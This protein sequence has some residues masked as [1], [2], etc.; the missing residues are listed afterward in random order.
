MKYNV[1][2]LGFTVPSSWGREL[3]HLDDQ[4][5]VQTFKFGWS[6]ARAINSGVGEVFLASSVPIQNYPRGRKI[7]FK[8]GRFA[9]GGIEGLMLGFV[10]VLLLKHVTRLF[11]CLVRLPLEIRRR[12]IGWIVLHGV[13]TPFL[14]FGLLARLFGIRLL[15]TLTDPAGVV[16]PTDSALTRMLKRCDASFIRWMVK[17]A[18][19]Y[20][21]LSPAMVDS[22]RLSKPSICFPGILNAGFQQA[23]AAIAR[24]PRDGAAERT[25]VYAGGLTSAYGV[26]SLIDAVMAIDVPQV[27]L[28]LYGRG[29]QQGRITELA[30]RDERFRYGGFVGDDELVPALLGADVLVNPRPAGKLFAVLSFPSKLIEYLATG[31]PLLSTKIASIPP[32]LIPYF[33]FV[34]EE[35]AEGI[36]AALL[37][38]LGALENAEEKATRG[39]LVVADELSEPAIGERISGLMDEI[40]NAKHNLVI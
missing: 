39:Q 7:L 29:D 32:T 8:G 23:V 5:A 16:L 27:R 20:M 40:I 26:D 30:S 9:E 2:L 12:R 35:G 14:L 28:V 25:I 10:N 31:R 33:N 15:V 6:L 37:K 13:H 18:D 34:Q 19:G 11:S 38:L 36:R 17:R 22:F 24:T 4:P 21:C 1:L 3:P